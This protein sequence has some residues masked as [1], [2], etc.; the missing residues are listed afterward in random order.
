[1]ESPAS[2]PS[3]SN[4]KDKVPLQDM[5]L[6]SLRELTNDILM[7]RYK[8]L[9][10]ESKDAFR[11]MRD[12]NKNC[13]QAG[14]FKKRNTHAKLAREI[15]ERHKKTRQQAW[16]K[17]DATARVCAERRLIKPKGSFAGELGATMLIGGRAAY[18]KMF[19]R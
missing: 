3:P 6:E 18:E 9:S 7:Q 10:K 14:I 8:I 19:V 17:A 13:K 16:D 4:N 5:T 2:A 15:K 12:S 11:K 1:M